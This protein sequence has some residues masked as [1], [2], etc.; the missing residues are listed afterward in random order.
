MTGIYARV[1]FKEEFSDD[2]WEQ[3]WITSQH[4]SKEWGKFVLTPGRYYGDPEI[5]KGIKTAEDEKFYGLT[6]KFEPFSNKGKVLVIQF[7]VKYEESMKCAGAYL[8][9]FDCSFNPKNF[10]S[11]VPYL[12]MFGPDICL[13]KKV[14]VIFSY[15]NRHVSTKERIRCREDRFTHL[16]TLII[17]PNNTYIVKIDNK[18]ERSGKL[19]EDFDFLP[20][21]KNLDTKKTEQES[22]VI[23]REF[24]SNPDSKTLVHKNHGYV[25]DLDFYKYDEICGVGFD[26]F[27]LESG[28]IFDNILITDDEFEAEKHGN[29]TWG[30]FTLKEKIMKIKADK[31]VK[32]GRKEEPFPKARTINHDEF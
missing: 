12:M 9:L 27:Q 5:S 15:K 26:L 1:Y 10:H 13:H 22:K 28:T 21:R 17:K 11:Y 32:T 31:E 25:S 29:D 23:G 24:T 30:A 18:I 20:P 2:A 7:S 14:H 4:A 6:T 8:K 3:R 19:E 16:Y